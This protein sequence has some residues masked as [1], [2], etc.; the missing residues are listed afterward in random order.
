MTLNA[1]QFEQ[2]RMF[3]PAS[4]IKAT[5]V[6]V[7]QRS[8]DI[9]DLYAEKLEESRAPDPGTAS[10]LSTPHRT[11]GGQPLYDSIA[12]HGV[13]SPVNSY[14]F[15]GSQE[16]SL[17]DGH[18]R[19]AVVHDRDPD[20]LVP[21]HYDDDDAHRYRWHKN[22]AAAAAGRRPVRGHIDAYLS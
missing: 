15:P 6:H 14:L 18:H 22:E 17:V 21:I 7:D 20:G 1:G 8:P 19:V 16:R 4:E 9:D 5:T 12:E 2:L 13:Q 11:Y 10:R 3:V